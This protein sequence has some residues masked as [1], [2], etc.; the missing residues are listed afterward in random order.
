MELGWLLGRAVDSLPSELLREIPRLDAADLIVLGARDGLELA[1]AGVESIS[2]VVRIVRPDSVADDPVAIAD[3]AVST[4]DA[5]GP[6]WLHVD[7]DVLS[8]ESLAAVDYRQVGGLDWSALTDV[9]ARAFASPSLLGWTLTIYN[10][11]LD[12]DGEG[13]QRIVRYVTDA[14]TLATGGPGRGDRH[15]MTR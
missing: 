9:T 11:D 7:L 6:W 4:L 13:A 1:E 12:A 3:R 14:F 8:T 15:R 5:R 10:P 2:D